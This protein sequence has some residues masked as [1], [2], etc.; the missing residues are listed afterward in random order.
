M[1]IPC[2]TQD[3][4]SNKGLGSAVNIQLVVVHRM[5]SCSVD[6]IVAALLGQDTQV[7]EVKIKHLRQCIEISVRFKSRDNTREISYQHIV[8]DVK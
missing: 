2:L 1:P 5:F 4:E 8:H 6:K 7:E 3:S